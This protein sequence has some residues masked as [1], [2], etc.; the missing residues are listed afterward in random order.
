MRGWRAVA[1]SGVLALVVGCASRAAAPVAAA[2]ADE[3][4]RFLELN[5]IHVGDVTTMAYPMKVVDDMNKEDAVLVLACGDVSLDG[6]TD[7][8]VNAKGVLDGLRVPYHA[9]M[10]NH[11]ASFDGDRDERKWKIIFGQKQT[12]YAVESHGVYFVGIDPGSGRDFKHN[13]VK[14]EVLATLAEIARGI[15]V[16]APV[17]LFSHYPYGAGVKYQTPNATEVLAVFRQQRV[18][19]AVGAHFHG[20]TERRDNG[21]LYTTTAAGGSTRANHDGTPQKGYR[22]FT[23]KN[24][25]EITTAFHEVPLLDPGVKATAV[26]TPAAVPA[27]AP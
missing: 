8:L 15:P 14:P 5:D 25:S 12:T 26:A 3:V 23:V 10:G 1:T 27:P 7:E 9:V 17:V 6:A 11:D 19:A 2:P 24:R 21:V 22:V 20:N 16:G 13:A 4:F 18:L